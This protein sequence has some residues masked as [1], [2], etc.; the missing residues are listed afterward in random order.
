MSE[1]LRS[2]LLT[3]GVAVTMS[4]ESI[5]ITP[6]SWNV[7]L[8]IKATIEVRKDYIDDFEDDHDYLE[9]L[10]TI[11]P[12]AEYCRDIVKAGVRTNRLEAEKLFLIE[13]FEKDVLFYFERD[14]FPQ[15]YVR[16]LYKELE[17]KISATRAI[18]EKRSD[19]FI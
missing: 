11:L 10:S 8:S 9:I 14:D 16:N 13:A 7:R 18:R 2:W 4:D 3:N 19:A 6:D 12:V 15:R 17:K 5:H 1:I